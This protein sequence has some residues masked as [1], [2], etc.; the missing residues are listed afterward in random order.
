MAFKNRKKNYALYETTKFADFREMVE[1]VADRVPDKVAFQYKEDPRQ[2]V[3]NT[4]TFAECREYV[5]AL[6]P[7]FTQDRLRTSR[8]RSS[9][10]HLSIGLC[11]T[12]RLCA[13]VR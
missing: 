3:A 12:P 9:A 8:S 1:N 7:S 4:K 6:Q 5:R 10:E 13:L 2:K 11:P